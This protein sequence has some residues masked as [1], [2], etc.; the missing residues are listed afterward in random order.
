MT[1]SQHCRGESQDV[2][3][4]GSHCSPNVGELQTL[5]GQPVFPWEETLVKRYT[6]SPA[7]PS[8]PSLHLPASAHSYFRLQNQTIRK[9]YLHFKW[10]TWI[11]PNPNFNYVVFIKLNTIGKTKVYLQHHHHK[12]HGQKQVCFFP[13]TASWVGSP[14]NLLDNLPGLISVTSLSAFYTNWAEI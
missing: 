7:C 13:K 10:F 6:F 11:S 5:G 2:P 8:L 9:G 1:A 4:T 14:Q 3:L 12:I